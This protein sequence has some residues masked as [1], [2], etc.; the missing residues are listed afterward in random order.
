MAFTLPT[1]PAY[2]NDAGQPVYLITGANKAPRGPGVKPKFMVIH[3]TAGSDSRKYLWQNE[4]GVS[5]HYLLGVY[6]DAGITPR[7]YK[8]ASE[9]LEQTF[10]QGFSTIGTD[11]NPNPESISLELE[12]PPIQPQVRVEAA[13]LVASILRY[14]AGRGVSLL[15]I[16]H[17]HI[18]TQGKQDPDLPW[19]AWCSDVYRQV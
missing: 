6:P 9:T 7:V 5:T 2:V 13:K 8:Y 1:S 3:H 4:R 14:W 17:K 19:T 12:G 18:D 16:G 15:L 11:T 10:T